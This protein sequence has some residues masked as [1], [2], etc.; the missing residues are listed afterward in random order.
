M[1]KIKFEMDADL[2]ILLKGKLEMDKKS[3]ENTIW[4]LENEAPE[5]EK[6]AVNSELLIK[7]LKDSKMKYERLLKEMEDKEDE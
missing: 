1:K 7:D 5:E 3:I 4:Y 6:Q 2:F